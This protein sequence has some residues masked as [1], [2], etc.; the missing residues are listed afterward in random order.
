MSWFPSEVGLKQGV[1]TGSH[2]LKAVGL[3]DIFW[4][5]D[6]SME[7]TATLPPEIIAEEILEDLRAALEQLERLRGL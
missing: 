4:L 6:E 5:R 7:D 3:L 1:R 2:H